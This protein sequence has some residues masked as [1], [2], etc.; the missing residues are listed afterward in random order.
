[1]RGRG[2]EGEKERREAWGRVGGWCVGLARSGEGV[3]RGNRGSSVEV[4][5]WVWSRGAGS[6]GEG[7]QVANRGALSWGE[8]TED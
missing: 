3:H 1:M 8:W 4:D 7:G 6:K 2:T 5:V